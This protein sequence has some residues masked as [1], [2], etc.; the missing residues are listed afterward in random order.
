VP[1]W[2]P[3]DP[4]PDGSYHHST[5]VWYP[6]GT[7]EGGIYQICQ[8]GQSSAGE[9]SQSSNVFEPM[10]FI[11]KLPFIQQH[12]EYFSTIDNLEKKSWTSWMEEAALAILAAQSMP[13]FD[14]AIDPKLLAFAKLVKET[15]LAQRVWALHLRENAPQ[16]DHK[17]GIHPEENAA[18]VVHENVSQNIHVNVRRQRLKD[19]NKG[20]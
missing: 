8:P 20:K 13:H 14:I 11:G 16:H 18:P 17:N 12:N 6:N 2:P 15:L 19:A 9:N 5:E 10:S 4:G 3:E 1:H 7:N